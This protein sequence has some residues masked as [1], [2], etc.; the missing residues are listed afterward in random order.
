LAERRRVLA[1]VF[2]L[3]LTVL[4]LQVV[5]SRLFAGLIYN[6]LY[7]FP[8]SMAML[9]LCGGGVLLY[10][11]EERFPPD[12]AE[13]ARRSLHRALLASLLFAGAVAL[14]NAATQRGV[15][16][17]LIEAALRGEDVEPPFFRSRIGLLFAYGGLSVLP[18]YFL[19]LAI[20]ALL[21]G[22]ARIVNTVYFT[23]LAGATL[24]AALAVPVL[25][26]LRSGTTLL[27]A[28]LLCALA[29]AI[30][31]RRGRLY[32]AALLPLGLLVQVSGFPA[33]DAVTLRALRYLPEYRVAATR[34]TSAA[35][36]QLL[37]R[38]DRP[39]RILQD[40]LSSVEVEPF[41]PEE[42]GCALREPGSCRTGTWLALS[43]ALRGLPASVCVLAAGV[44][45]QMVEAWR[46]GVPEIVGVEMNPDL[47]P[48][49]AAQVPEARLTQLGE[50]PGVSYVVDEARHAMRRTQRRF[51]LILIPPSGS[52]QGTAMPSTPNHLIT[53]EAVAEYLE[54]LS[55]RGLLLLTVNAPWQPWGGEVRAGVLDLIRRG[56]A[57]VGIRDADAHVVGLE[58]GFLFVSP[59]PFAPEELARVAS[60]PGGPQL[61][62]LAELEAGLAP[63][64]LPISD[65]YP[66]WQGA[67]SFAE[68]WH[69][70]GWLG[71]SGR[72]PADAGS[73]FALTNLIA[74]A[75]VLGVILFPL[76]RTRRGRPGFA[77]R[78][79]LAIAYFFCLGAGFMFV[80]VPLMEELV[81]VLGNPVYSISFCLAVLLAS[82]G[83]GSLWSGRLLWG[84]GGLRRGRLQVAFLGLLV[85]QL[86]LYAGVGALLAGSLALPGWLQVA[87]VGLAI[88]PLGLLLGV[89]FPQGV[90]L[91]RDAGRSSLIPWAWGV[92]GAASV[93]AINA[94]LVLTRVVGITPMFLLALLLYLG[95]FA[96]LRG[97]LLRAPGA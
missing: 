16:A 73:L 75:L 92:N 8:L 17:P 78:D 5:L 68:L 46:A 13:L 9:G 24:G 26:H 66:F 51:D 96:L 36:L 88:V 62:S 56:L 3:S 60:L 74:L 20:A 38:E 95:A 87:A 53:E 35:Y 2:L 85:L 31:E 28:P 19:G 33:L 27:I 12:A 71:R 52:A 23:D 41:V 81:F 7:Y 67:S 94:S 10:A 79:Q 90:A 97:A 82:T 6:E 54:R 64:R 77:A 18:F 15:D 42:R 14:L 37:E 55:D 84:A 63:P 49:A 50:S 48:F 72:E 69:D 93:L 39:A 21:K 40:H 22:Y 80:E 59:R 1:T 47:L 34:W 4:L 32:L 30:W 65:D 57:R 44:G 11:F 89:P 43:S 25:D 45:S 61:R 83:L 91:L 58:P 86:G 70:L 76:L 29:L